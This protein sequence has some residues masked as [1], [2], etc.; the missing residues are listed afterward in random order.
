MGEEW[1]HI[2]VEGLILCNGTHKK[3]NHLDFAW[4]RVIAAVAPLPLRM[5][6]EPQRST[7]HVSQ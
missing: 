7:G 1:L 6:K 3:I 5:K 2:F 4:K